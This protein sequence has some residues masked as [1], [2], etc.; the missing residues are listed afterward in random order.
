[1][2]N[3]IFGDAVP[4]CEEGHAEHLCS[5]DGGAERPLPEDGVGG[6]P[7]RRHLDRLGFWEGGV[8]DGS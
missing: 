1:M 3:Y 8:C 2:N 6:D 4:G 7:Q 5:E